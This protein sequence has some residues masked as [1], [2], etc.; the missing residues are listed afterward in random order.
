LWLISF[1]LIFLEKPKSVSHSQNNELALDHSSSI[2]GD[3]ESMSLRPRTESKDMRK[4]M[5]VNGNYHV[6]RPHH[7]HS[8]TVLPPKPHSAMSKMPG[9]EFTRNRATSQ[10]NAATNN[11]SSH[12][13]FTHDDGNSRRNSIV[14]KNL[15]SEN[16]EVVKVNGPST[17]SP[18]VSSSLANSTKMVWF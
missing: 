12:T 14:V 4:S 9:S 2:Y 18:S 5:D 17:E 3:A 7:A 1:S 15:N 16:A 10:N 13:I 11:S 8:D 6:Q